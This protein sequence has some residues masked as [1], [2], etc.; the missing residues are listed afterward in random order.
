MLATD[1]LLDVFGCVGREDLDSWNVV[2]KQFRKIAPRAAPLRRVET[3][4]AYRDEHGEYEAV[5]DEVK[6]FLVI[7]PCFCLQ[8]HGQKAV[9]AMGD[10]TDWEASFFL[11]LARIVDRQGSFDEEPSNRGGLR[12]HDARHKAAMELQ[13]QVIFESRSEKT[14]C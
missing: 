10:S 13:R 12:G 5:I 3:I 1:S 14:P 2:S 11:S 4:Q 7:S 6:M 9:I 8:V